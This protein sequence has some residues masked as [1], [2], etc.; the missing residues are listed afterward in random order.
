MVMAIYGKETSYG[1]VTGDF[2]DVEQPVL[3]AWASDD[4]FFPFEHAE[5][6][7]RDFPNST[8]TVIEGS[9]TWVSEDRPEELASA[10][11]RFVGDAGHVQPT[12]TLDRSS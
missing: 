3:V 1:A 5:R 4:K 7:A 6:L 12:A 9:R 11:T 8:L 10:I 2:G